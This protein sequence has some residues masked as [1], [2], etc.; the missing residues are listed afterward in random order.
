MTRFKHTRKGFL[1]MQPWLKM[2]IAALLLSSCSVQ[3]T[4]YD[5]VSSS[6]EDAPTS[7]PPMLIH[8]HPHDL[9]GAGGDDAYYWSSSKKHQIFKQYG[10]NPTQL[11]SAQPTSTF[12]MD[13]D[14]GSYQLALTM[15][16]ANQMPAEAGIRVEEFVNAFRYQYRSN[17]AMTLSAEA[18]PSPFRKGYHLLHLGVQ[19]QDIPDDQRLPANIVFVVDI[20]SSMDSNDKMALQKNALKSLI[21]QLNRDDRVAIVSYSDYAR[22]ELQPTEAHKKRKIF[23]A[24]N[25]L[26]TEGSTN[27]SHGISTGYQLADQMFEPGMVNRVV[28]TSDGMA[29]VGSSEP[30]TILSK[31][32]EYKDQGIFLTTVGFGREVFNDYLLEQLA[33]KGN[34]HY[35]YIKS[36]RDVEKR[37]V[38]GLS[39]QLQVVAKNAKIQVNFNPESVSHY[40]LLGYENRHLDNDEFLDASKD[41][42]ELGAGHRVT[43]LYEIKLTNVSKE[44]GKFSI[45]YQKPEGHKV[46]TL[47]KNIPHQIVRKDLHQAS[48]DLKLSASAAAFAEKLRLSY[49]SSFYEYSH[50]LTLLEQLPDSYLS[51]HQVSELKSAVKTASMIDRRRSPHDD[52][53]KIT[54]ANLDHVPLLN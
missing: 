10:V 38:D 23:K 11:A 41:G 48:A 16:N 13:V 34:G 33:N 51:T 22:I 54:A 40:R 27:V 3:H 9:P 30:E 17:G 25:R 42:G 36:K 12:G 43:A 52:A 24:I 31:V 37:F 4:I 46:H 14:D 44:L 7:E 1:R 35:L 20:S 2:T 28:L 18:M 8:N 5:D 29:N 47:E 53:S 39:Q 32:Q 50:V 49:W 26:E 45:A 19:T 6:I 15:L 21:G